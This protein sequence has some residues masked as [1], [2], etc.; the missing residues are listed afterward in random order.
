MFVASC[1][2]HLEYAGSCGIGLY[3][4]SVFRLWIACLQEANNWPNFF[5][6][7]LR[8][9]RFAVIAGNDGEF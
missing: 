3:S 9:F 4:D 6:W 7:V 2:E 8:V 5:C 1:D